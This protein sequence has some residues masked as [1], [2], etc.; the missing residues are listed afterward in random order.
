MMDSSTVNRP[1]AARVRFDAPGR[2]RGQQSDAHRPREA[3]RRSPLLVGATALAML[4][5]VVV[6]VGSRRLLGLSKR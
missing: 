4:A 3:A 1:Q 2:L 6:L 5:D